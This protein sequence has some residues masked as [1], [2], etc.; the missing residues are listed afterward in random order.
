MGSAVV[1]TEAW[2]TSLATRSDIW[3]PGAYP[4]GDA[5]TLEDD[6]GGVSAGIVGSNDFD[7]GGHFGRGPFR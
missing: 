6:G 2:A 5:V 1:A 3:A 4:V 7:G